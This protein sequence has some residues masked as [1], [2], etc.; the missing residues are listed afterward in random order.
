MN[1]NLVIVALMIFSLLAGGDKALAFWEQ[2]QL[3]QAVYDD[4][5][6][7]QAQ[8]G[9]A[10][11][12]SSLLDV[13]PV[14]DLGRSFEL[15][16]PGSISPQQQFQK[17][18]ADLR[19]GF[20]AYY[21][22]NTPP[23][24]VD[25]YFTTTLPTT[26]AIS[27]AMLSAFQSNAKKIQDSYAG[28]AASGQSYLLAP[29]DPTMCYDAKMNGA[30]ASPGQYSGFNRDLVYGE[31]SLASLAD[32][33]KID[34]YLYR[35]SYNL[36]TKS[37]VPVPGAANP[38]L[39]VLN[40]FPDGS[41]W[42]NSTQQPPTLSN[43]DGTQLADQTIEAN[44]PF[45]LDIKSVDPNGADAVTLSVS[46]LPSGASLDPASGKLSWAP[47]TSDIGEYHL[48]IKATDD[49]G[50]NGE[51]P[52][53]TTATMTITVVEGIN[54]AP[55]I[56]PLAAQ[57]G[58]ENAVLAFTV[59]ATD[60]EGNPITYAASDLPAGATLNP[61]T[62]VFSWTPIYGEAGTYTVPFIATDSLGAVS[63]PVTVTITIAHTNQPPALTPISNKSATAGSLLTFTVSASDP[64]GDAITLSVSSLPGGASFDPASGM[65]SWTPQADDVNHTFD[66]TI[67]A[68]DNGSPPL[69]DTLLL[70]ITVAAAPN[71]APTIA[72]IT[73]KNGQ[74]NALLSFTVAATDPDEN[75]ISFAATGLP[76]GATLNPA[77]G[78][79]SWTPGYEQ[80]GSYT[81]TCTATD[82]FGAASAPVTASITIAHTNRPPV[83][84]PVS[85]KS[86]A[87]GGL[88]TFTV[89]AADPD[90][91]ALALGATSLP[92]GAGFD[93][94]SGVFSWTPNFG[95][96][97]ATPYAATFTANDNSATATQTVAITVSHTNRPPLLV[98]PGAQA[99]TEGTNLAFTL[100]ASDP[101]NNT[102]T[103]AATGLPS[104][105]TLNPSTGVFSWISDVGASGNSPYSVTFMVSDGLS[106]VSQT[107]QIA[108]AVS[109]QP[110]VPPLAKIPA[111]GAQVGNLALRLEVQPVANRPLDSCSY[112]FLLYSGSDLQTPMADSSQ[113]GTISGTVWQD[114]A[115]T[116]ANN[117]VYYWRA[118]ATDQNNNS[119]D[120]AS[121]LYSFTT[122]ANFASPSVPQVMS[123][124][125]GQNGA[126]TVANT[127]TPVLAVF[128]ATDGDNN[129]LTYSFEIYNNAA[130]SKDGALPLVSQVSELAQ[131]AGTT[132]WRM[133]ISLT[134]GST[135]YWRVSV[136][137][138]QHLVWMPTASF[139]V[140]T[141]ATD[142][143]M[144]V[145][146]DVATAVTPSRVMTST[147]E[148]SDNDSVIQG[149]G[150]ELPPGSLI[151]PAVIEIG[152]AT[153]TPAF[154]GD[155]VK[156]G[157]V[158]SFS[159]VSDSGAD[160]CPAG[161]NCF[162][163]PVTIKIPYADADLR[164][165]G[166]GAP[167]SLQIITYD[168][169]NSAWTVVPH[170]EVDKTNKMVVASVSHFSLYALG[171]V[172][173]SDG[174]APSASTT[175]ADGGGGGCFIATA[176]FGSILEPQVKTLRQFRDRFLLT[177]GPGRLFVRLY[178]SLSPPIADYIAESDLLRAVVRFLLL[179]FI[180]M[181]WLAVNAGPVFMM[182]CFI[183][184]CSGARTILLLIARRGRDGGASLPRT[185][186]LNFS[187]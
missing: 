135:Y 74:E 184:S 92:S 121:P 168:A 14:A 97:S 1:R 61:S 38:Y 4:A 160:L 122:A 104:G 126:V 45:V 87:E 129:Q 82:N 143:A 134:D 157:R 102:L 181:G 147:V 182:V 83:L 133:P 118:I 183:A 158:I 180:G 41:T 106:S 103:F 46:G 96:S 75:V 172:S 76:V 58:Q 108:V 55:T 62:G 81:V 68:T 101:D 28:L 86:V 174:G 150:V 95:T 178:Y 153:N 5:G 137:D 114:I 166:V 173:Q 152:M 56:A 12:V 27:S 33:G 80:A 151:Q 31:V 3:I 23:V 11:F 16:P 90:G 146:L 142:G 123:P 32:G 165:A 59:A 91:D 132:T 100:S 63:T 156:V 177:N 185:G 70:S 15:M 105:A 26:P 20:F 25:F 43:P 187:R 116:L 78:V 117:T 154:P 66:L 113:S 47:K 149:S 42:L 115:V 107:V 125:R 93:P 29:P 179:P 17:T 44:L 22:K 48:T 79:F 109:S 6:P 131:V 39:C 9:N 89:V 170:S 138:G 88:L 10:E 176:A 124:P 35:F 148:V 145:D 54:R 94:A 50:P 7:A 112:R 98:N 128:N 141:S 67:T 85:A 34:M 119:S 51:P 155:M 110:P 130:L 140:N 65:C 60:P 111:D 18:W 57:H 69:A 71:Q 127:L 163:T 52:L 175:S 21:F 37:M 84:T 120:A 169:R 40:I 36:A 136:S 139:A 161:V 171:V 2:Y 167:E 53:A 72:P 30:S 49:G 73:A 64:D 99:T 13:S 24:Q 144:Q 164:Q 19:L 162:G 159:M 8:Y 186:T 77:T